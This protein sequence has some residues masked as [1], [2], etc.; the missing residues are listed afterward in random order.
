MAAASR[1]RPRTMD[2]TRWS[3]AVA[4]L[5]LG[6]SAAGE[7]LGVVQT[8]AGGPGP[9]A[10]AGADA[11]PDFADADAGGDGD[12]S[13]ACAA[14][15]PFG[16]PALIAELESTG[17]EGGFRLLDD[18]LTGFF[19]STR[20][21]GQGKSYLYVTT[22][23]DRASPFGAITLLDNVNTATLQVDPTVVASG[24]Y[25]AFRSEREG[26]VGGYDLYSAAR[27]SLDASF[28]GV[29][30]LSALDSVEDDVQPF[31]R[32]DGAE[33]Y[34]ASNRAGDYDLY[35][36]TVTAGVYTPPAP[37]AELNTSGFD[38]GDPVVSADDK[39]VFFSSTR[40]GG[41]G[42]SDVWTATRADPG[43]PFGPAVNVA[44]LNTAAFEDPTWL[45][46]DGCRLYLS[47]QDDAG[48]AHIYVASRGP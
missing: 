30:L 41:A 9:A 31:L 26:G 11:T 45:S 22:R 1:A 2:A 39:T 12:A 42:A 3:L 16:A 34:F 7:L 25:L 21:G 35:R 33:I 4:A 17:A 37:V 38:D 27:G 15:D 5:C 13:I 47:R 48:R 44:V 32:A 19:W 36:S 10:D 43:A 40:P 24:L 23:P 8:D 6:C 18:E 29:T 46:V 14:T 20:P 28:D